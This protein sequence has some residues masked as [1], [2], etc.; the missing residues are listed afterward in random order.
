MLQITCKCG[1]EMELIH[2]T[3]SGMVICSGCLT[4]V[5]VPGKGG[6]R[7]M[8]IPVLPL[9]E[10]V[11]CRKCRN[12]FPGPTQFVGRMMRC[13]ACGKRIWRKEQRRKFGWD[14]KWASEEEMDTFGLSD[15]TADWLR[16]YPGLYKNIMGLVVL[17]ALLFFFFIYMAMNA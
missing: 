8:A 7:E 17:A 15:M 16:W 2:P 12:S 13:P 1:R 4:E 5:S 14:G 9:E 11:T 3:Q 10:W 6:R